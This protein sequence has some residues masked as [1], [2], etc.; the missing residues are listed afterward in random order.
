MNINQLTLVENHWVSQNNIDVES[1]LVLVF[2]STYHIKNLVGFHELKKLYPKAYI[3][4]CSTAGEF[5]NNNVTYEQVKATAIKFNNIDIIHKSITIVKKD[6][7]KDKVVELA[8]S[9][10][11]VHNEKP[12]VHLLVFSVGLNLDGDSI[13]KGLSQA[14][15]PVTGGMAGDSTRFFETYVL[16]DEDTNKSIV[17]LGFYSNKL[18][19][20]SYLDSSGWKPIGPERKITKSK[21]VTIYEFTNSKQEIVKALPLYKMYL[22]SK[23]NELPLSGLTMPLGFKTT[24]NGLDYWIVRAPLAVNEIEESIIYAANIPEDTPTK[25][26]SSTPAILVEGS[27]DCADRGITDF[28]CN[29]DFVLAIGCMARCFV[30]SDKTSDE[31]TSMIEVLQNSPVSGFYSYGEYCPVGDHNNFLNTYH[32]QTM[33]LT[34]FKEE[35]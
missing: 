6:E 14:G 15:V 20:G 26:M 34:F 33:T 16:D 8:M 31:L 5:L 7:L 29:P 27:R 1:N 18:K 21:D 22:G 12:L 32:N 3:T 28:G 17:V 25:F 11:K 19:V 4:G 24:V 13:V 10:P 35:E 23:A 30:L 2:G 9:F